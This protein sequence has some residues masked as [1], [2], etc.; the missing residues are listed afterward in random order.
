MFSPR[1][2][3]SIFAAV[4]ITLVSGCTPG[5]VP[6]SADVLQQAQEVFRA[7]AE[8]SGVVGGFMLIRSGGSDHASSFGSTV[9]GGQQEPTADTVFRIGSTTKTFTGTL[10]LQLVDEGLLALDDPVSRYRTD[11]PRGEDI[12]I[13]MLLKM[14]S[15]LANYTDDNAWA[16]L[17]MTNPTKAVDPEEMLA[18]AFKQDLLFEPGSKYQYSNTNTV[19]LGV[20]AEALTGKNLTTLVSERLTVP[21]GLKNTGIP[22]RND[23]TLPQPFAHGYSVLDEADGEMVDVTDFNPSWA[24]GAGAGFSTSAE[25]ADWVEALTGGRLL[26]EETQKLR[27]N[28]VVP[29]TEDTGPAS[30]G[31]GLGIARIAGL[32]GHNGQLPGYNSYMGSDPSRALTVVIWVNLAPNAAGESPAQ[33]IAD[34]VVPLLLEQGSWPTK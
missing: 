14:R 20:I 25:L 23:A 28:S 34:K 11:V 4:G 30:P 15:G 9:R 17:I 3:I 19:L 26:R 21:L 33:K 32:Y 1:R 24:S 22:E 18:I 5:P 12:T 27:M 29:V 7:T 31:Y 16:D 8:A 10:I 2:I 13:E 6:L